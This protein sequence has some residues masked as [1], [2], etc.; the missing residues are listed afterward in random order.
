MEPEEA[1]KVKVGDVL[2]TKVSS[3]IEVCDVVEVVVVTS[4]WATTPQEPKF[5]LQRRS[6]KATDDLGNLRPAAF[7]WREPKQ[8]NWAAEH[9]CKKDPLQANVYADFLDEQGFTEAAARLRERF[10]VGLPEVKEDDSPP[11]DNPRPDRRRR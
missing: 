9:L 2:I 8:V 1:R 10:P 4:N 11:L 5:R 7:V 3:K 6:V